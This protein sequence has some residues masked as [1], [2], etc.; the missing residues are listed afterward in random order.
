VLLRVE[1]IHLGQEQGV[2]L[3]VEVTHLGQGQSVLLRVE[4]TL[5]WP[6]AER[7]ITS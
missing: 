4:V 7:I 1:V 2:L 3:C 6:R 5:S